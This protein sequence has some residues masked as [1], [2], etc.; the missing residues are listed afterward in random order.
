MTLTKKQRKDLEAI[1]KLGTEVQSMMKIADEQ[2]AA[3]NDTL[4]EEVSVEYFNAIF[5]K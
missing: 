5:A 4:H 3:T 2:I 1:S